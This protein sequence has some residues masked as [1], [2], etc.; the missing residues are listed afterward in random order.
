MLAATTLTT[1]DEIIEKVCP[2][3]RTAGM[4]TINLGMVTGNTIIVLNEDYTKIE[5]KQT[6]KLQRGWYNDEEMS[7]IFREG[8]SVRIYRYKNKEIYKLDKKNVIKKLLE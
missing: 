7:L 8:D 2:N 6:D 5:I 1:V 4:V 3:G